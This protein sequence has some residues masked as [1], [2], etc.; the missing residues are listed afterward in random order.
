M[1][2]APTGE[3]GFTLTELLIATAIM[4]AVVAALFSV[5]NPAE[6]AFQAQPEVADM[7]QRLRVGVD[8]LNR[9][10]L[11]AGA[12]I[13]SGPAVGA[14]GNFF[15]PVMP[16]RVGA[17]GSDPPGT[18]RTDAI[19]L[20]SVPETCA[21]TTISQAMPR[22]SN[23]LKVNPEPGC[24][25]NDQ[26]CC[27]AE[28]MQVVI[29]DSSGAWNTFTITSVQTPAMHLQRHGPDFVKDYDSGAMIAQVVPRTYYLK[30]DDATKTYQLMY[31][32][33]DQT[34]VPLVDN[35][36]GLTFEYFGEPQPPAL[37]KPVSDPT[38][39]WTTYGP[40][41]PAL[42]V[43]GGMGYPDG[44]NCT[45]QVGGGQQVSR[46]PVLG[47]GGTGLVPLTQQMLTDGPWC[48]GPDSQGRFDA[49][50]FRIRRIR[51]TLRVQSGLQQLRGPAGPLF[52]KGGYSRGGE[53]FV[54][55][56][57]L[58][59]DVAPRNLNLGR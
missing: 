12:G 37:L 8:T 42:G 39:P 55:D 48:P 31:Y 51:V 57:E 40:K 17:V 21:Q 38:G 54:P 4:M 22:N 9:D 20:L 15:A 45:F 23:E 6:G 56:Q 33:G 36:V 44:E 32:D 25:A 14:L 11:N 34:D 16:Y 13:Y 58:R 59:F 27:F 28:G 47:G 26:L 43:S 30:S 29:F 49:D 2:H 41:P 18:F 1:R 35:V 10:L 5:L 53:M 46:L 3:A 7:Q 19:T 52:A 50:L 24:P